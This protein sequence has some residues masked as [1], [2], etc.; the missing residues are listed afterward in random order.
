[1]KI[2]DSGPDGFLLI[3]PVDKTGTAGKVLIPEGETKLT[4]ITEYREKRYVTITPFGYDIKWN[5]DVIEEDGFARVIMKKED[6]TISGTLS[7]DPKTVK[8]NRN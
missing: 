7:Y 5:G 4:L 2:I 8:R 6:K 3:S 1:L